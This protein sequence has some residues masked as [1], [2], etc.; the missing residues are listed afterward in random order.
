MKVKTVD[1]FKIEPYESKTAEVQSHKVGRKS[2]YP[3]HAL[4]AGRSFLVSGKVI[5]QVSPIVHYHNVHNPNKGIKFHSRSEE[6][7]VRVFAT[8]EKAAV[9]N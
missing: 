2:L 1:G 9:L 4:K 5:A 6:N 7:G 8:K 3:F